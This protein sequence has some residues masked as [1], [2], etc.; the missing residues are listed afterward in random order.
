MNGGG[1]DRP[2]PADPRARRPALHRAASLPPVLSVTPSTPDRGPPGTGPD[3]PAARDL[4]PRPRR[5][6]ERVG[7]SAESCRAPPGRRWGP[8]REA[9]AVPAVERPAG[10]DVTG[11]GRASAGKVCQAA[12]SRDPAPDRRRPDGRHNSLAAEAG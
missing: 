4:R 6:G 2:R 12:R 9:G 8:A 11:G 7:P 5:R 1:E 3:V 10:G